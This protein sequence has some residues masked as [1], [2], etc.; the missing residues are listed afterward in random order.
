[1]T[2]ASDVSALA[3][4][5]GGPPGAA[6]TDAELLAEIT[7]KRFPWGWMA[8]VLLVVAGGA[9]VWWRMKGTKPAQIRYVTARL[10]MGEVVESIE[11]TGTVQPLLQVQVGA[12]ASGRVLRVHTDF[13]QTVREGQLLAELDPDPF[14]TRVNE[15]R[16]A[17]ASARASLARARA[18]LLIRERDLARARDLRT[19]GLNAQAEVDTALGARDLSRAAINVSLAELARTQAT[20][21]SSR[22]LLAQSKIYAPMAGLVISRQVDPG[23][24]V[25]ASLQAPTMFIIAQDLTRMRVMADVDEADIGRMREGMAVEARVDAF[26]GERFRGTVTQLRYGATTT[27][28]VV[29]YPAVIE[30]PNPELKLRPGMTATVTVTTARLENVLRVPNAALR[31]RPS[32]SESNGTGARRGNGRADRDAGAGNNSGESEAPASRGGGPRS[33]RVFVLRE[34]RPTYVRVRIVASDG[35]HTAV[36]SPEL[37]EGTEVITDEIDES[38]SRSP[39]ASGSGGSGGGSSGSRSGSGGSRGP[40]MF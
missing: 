3:S 17:E 1:M 21:A 5:P 13:N 8:L 37:H 10:T 15:S 7:K 12:Q 20:L 31:F 11:A 22:N 35:T 28:G 23:Q 4:A 9:A 30:V 6:T 38:A 24:T 39:S 18:D 40:R 33:G 25:A 29:T 2:T 14:Q 36:E 19:R 26:Q 27:A 34:G 32:N 16:A